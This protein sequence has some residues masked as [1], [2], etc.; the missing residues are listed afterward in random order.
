MRPIPDGSPTSNG[1]MPILEDKPNAVREKPI[2]QLMVYA[3]AHARST[4]L[5]LSDV[6]GAWFDA[7]HDEALYPWHEVHTC[8][9]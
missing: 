5:R 8:R 9:R 7:R 1:R 2:T 4:G 3:L 6:G